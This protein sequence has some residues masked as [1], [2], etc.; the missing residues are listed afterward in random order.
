MELLF[1]LS[2]TLQPYNDGIV[3]IKSKH[4]KKPLQLYDVPSG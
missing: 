1:V 3:I 4:D 2:S